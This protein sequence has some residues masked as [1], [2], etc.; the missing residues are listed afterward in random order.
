KNFF[1]C[2]GGLLPNRKTV[3]KEDLPLLNNSYDAVFLDYHV[4]TDMPREMLD[5]ALI[6]LHFHA[7]NIYCINSSFTITDYHDFERLYID[8]EL[9]ETRISACG[10]LRPEFCEELYRAAKIYGKKGTILNIGTYFGRSAI[11]LALGS[12][13]VG[14]GKIIAIDPIIPAGFYENVRKN[15]VSDYIMPIQMPSR[16]AYAHVSDLIE[17]GLEAKM[18]LIFIDGAHCYEE[19]SFDLSY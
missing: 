7:P 17:N 5:N 8:T 12:K 19:V 11:A 18:G 15:N 4:W 6:F 1:I 16:E 9:K 14:G 13:K 3:T 10:I 2:R